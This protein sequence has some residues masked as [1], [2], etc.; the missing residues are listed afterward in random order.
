MTAA[1][2]NIKTRIPNN[3]P[4]TYAQMDQN[5]TTLQLNMPIG[6]VLAY[7]MTDD[8]PAT[9]AECDGSSFVIPT[10]ESDPT[11]SLYQVL[12]TYYNHGS[13]PGGSFSIPDSRGWFMRHLDPSSGVDPDADRI[14]GS[15]QED[16]FKSHTHTFERAYYSGNVNYITRGKHTS[17]IGDETVSATGGAETRPKNLAM[18]WIMKIYSTNL[19]A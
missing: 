7:W 15:T 14:V 1:F 5:L 13:T 19:V 4:L 6:S 12:G 8:I 16:S 10:D 9:W 17:P 11:W 18:L 2:V 3:A